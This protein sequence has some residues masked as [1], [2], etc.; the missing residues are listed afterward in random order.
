MDRLLELT[1]RAEATHFWFRGFRRFVRPLVSRAAAGRTDLRMLD[2]GCG[3]GYNLRW[4]AGYGVAIGMD[5]T[6]SGLQ[7]AREGGERV[8]RADA[9]RLP[10]ATGAFDLVASFDVLPCIPDDR[11]AI[12][13]IAR[14]LKPGGYLVAN[15]AALDVLYGDH[16]AFSAEV[17]RYTPGRLRER[18]EEA[19][20]EPLTIRFGFASIFPILLTLRLL[21]KV[22]RGKATPREAEITMPSPLVNAALSGLVLLEVWVSRMLPMP[23]GSSLRVL[24]RKPQ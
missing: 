21:Q 23:F 8:V 6:H 15:M 2:C 16:S 3:T 10:Y 20:L 4:L 9:M 5:L 24:A 12:A 14:V 17:R 11:V 1:Q 18:L 13:E 7:M 22:S 19:G